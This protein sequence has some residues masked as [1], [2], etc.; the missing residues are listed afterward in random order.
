M[1]INRRSSQTTATDEKL[2]LKRDQGTKKPFII[3]KE[4]LKISLIIFVIY[5]FLN[6]LHIG[7][8]IKFTT[9]ISCPGCGMTRSV[10]SV[11]RFDFK[12]ALYYHPLFFLTPFMFIMFLFEA[13]MKPKYLKIAWSLI[14]AAFIVVYIIR[15]FF[16]GSDVVEIDIWDGAVLKLIHQIYVGG[17]K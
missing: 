10:L 13:Y 15:L 8:P 2:V 11:L 9:G 7:C 1:K 4:R 6:F 12:T 16:T 5:L 17:F 3:F 14:I